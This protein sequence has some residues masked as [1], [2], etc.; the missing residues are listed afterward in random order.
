MK[1]KITVLLVLLISILCISG[2]VQYSEE[3]QFHEDDFS[4][5]V[6]YIIDEPSYSLESIQDTILDT[7]SATEKLKQYAMASEKIESDVNQKEDS[8]QLSVLKDKQKSEIKLKSKERIQ[9][10]ELEHMQTKENINDNL[11]QI[12]QQHLLIDSLLEQQNKKR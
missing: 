5:T 11:E 2:C 3:P 6:N 12:E 7:T 1:R 4:D 8:L 10:K 9:L